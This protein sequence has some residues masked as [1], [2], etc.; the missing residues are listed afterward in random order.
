MNGNPFHHNYRNKWSIGLFP[1]RTLS[2]IVL[3]IYMYVLLT[4]SLFMNLV[5]L[6]SKLLF[7]SVMMNVFKVFIPL[8][9][10]QNLIF[11]PDND[12]ILHKIFIKI[13]SRLEKYDLHATPKR[14]AFLFRP[15]K[16]GSGYAVNGNLGTQCRKIWYESLTAIQSMAEYI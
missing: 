4:Y 9:Q 13:I 8:Y 7:W 16:N 6:L 12:L 15:K 1:L 3:C 14:I 10:D 11:K 2:C 5:P